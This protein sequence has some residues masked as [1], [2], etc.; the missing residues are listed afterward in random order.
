MVFY[1]PS[2][3]IPIFGICLPIYGRF[4]PKI[5][6]YPKM[7]YLTTVSPTGAP[8]LA[9]YSILCVT[10]PK[11]LRG[12]VMLQCWPYLA[13]CVFFPV[14]LVL[15]CNPPFGQLWIT[16]ENI[17]MLLSSESRL[18]K[19]HALCWMP[20]RL[21]CTEVWHKR[22]CAEI[23]DQLCCRLICAKL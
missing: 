4:L 22:F 3:C 21:P 11:I 19:I 20:Q 10:H 12:A 2:F 17:V 13:Y 5:G 8:S 6:T 14:W 18:E 23:F 15:T 9:Y 16:K 7:E 1:S